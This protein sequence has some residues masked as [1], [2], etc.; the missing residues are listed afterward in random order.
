MYRRWGTILILKLMDGKSRDFVMSV[1]V[2]VG[3]S[4]LLPLL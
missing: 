4:A 2:H 3:S 1:R